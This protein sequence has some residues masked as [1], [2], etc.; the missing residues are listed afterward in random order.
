MSTNSINIQYRR[1]GRDYR[2]RT[3]GLDEIRESTLGNLIREDGLIT[4]LGDF[5]VYVRPQDSESEIAADNLENSLESILR[6]ASG[7]GEISGSYVV[8]VTAVHRGA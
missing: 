5:E 2:T 8:D 6:S 1:G 3:F 4:G 7:D